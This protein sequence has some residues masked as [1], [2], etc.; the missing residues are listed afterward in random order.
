MLDLLPKVLADLRFHGFGLALVGSACN[1]RLTLAAATIQ[2]TVSHARIMEMTGLHSV[3]ASRLLQ[4]LVRIG[5]LE[6]HNPGRG[7]VYCLPGAGLPT[8][9][10]VF[11]GSSEY[12]PESS[13]HLRGSSRHLLE[14]SNICPAAAPNNCRT[15]RAADRRARR[16]W[17]KACQPP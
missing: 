13:E 7:A 3:E 2:P 16:I 11:G 9:E 4:A 10:D 6:S 14:S 8:P 17:T 5:F 12:L 15:A 1:E